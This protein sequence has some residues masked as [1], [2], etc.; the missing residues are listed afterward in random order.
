MP[1]PTGRPGI[2]G[3]LGKSQLA[4]ALPGQS[5]VTTTLP[6]IK[7]AG[8]GLHTVG[9]PPGTTKTAPSVAPSAVT[10]PGTG[11]LPPHLRTPGPALGAQHNPHGLDPKT[12][13]GK[14]SNMPKSPV[15]SSAGVASIIGAPKPVA[16]PTTS[17]TPRPAV[18]P[19]GAGLAAAG[20]PSAVLPKI[21]SQT[22]P[23]V[24]SKP[25]V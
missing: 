1:G 6:A 2:F 22:A 14:P 9:G 20:A 10:Q 15:A 21:P 23:T 19:A 13:P 18:K 24:A 17:L 8:S 12:A 25:K 16:K 3:R 11:F 4:K 5:S 7:P